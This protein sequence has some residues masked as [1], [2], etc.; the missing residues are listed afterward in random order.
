MA[1]EAMALKAKTPPQ[2]AQI[3][4]LSTIFLVPRLRLRS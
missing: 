4:I 2:P 3:E 1:V